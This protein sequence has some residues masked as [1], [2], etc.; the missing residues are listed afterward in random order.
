MPFTDSIEMQSN[1]NNMD[2]VGLT[3][4]GTD[5]LKVYER[6]NCLHLKHCIMTPAHV[7][8]VNYLKTEIPVYFLGF[9]CLCADLSC[10]MN[11]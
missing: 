11:L 7:P 8:A 9:V 10:T 4:L 1:A 5:E 6:E 2:V 3:T